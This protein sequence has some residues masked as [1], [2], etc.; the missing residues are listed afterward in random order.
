MTVSHL[1]DYSTKK[2]LNLIIN[3]DGGAR[4]NPG[5]AAIGVVIQDASGALL[6]SHKAR[7]GAQT[8]NVAE[9]EALLYALGWLSR[10][11]ADQEVQKCSFLLDSKLVIEQ[12]NGK[13]KVKEAHLQTFVKK[14]QEIIHSLPFP[15]TLSYV[16]RAKNAVADALVNEAL[17]E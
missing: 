5:P 3:T 12:V 8:N 17:D 2:L 7:L 6:H 13:W 15:I 9:Y 16:P 11:Q 10:F 14:A 1:S 4:G